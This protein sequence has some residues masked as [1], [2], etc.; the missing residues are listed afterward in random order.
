MWNRYQQL[1]R[2][3]P[4]F[5]CQI[6]SA[7]ASGL[8]RWVALEFSNYSMCEQPVLD[9]HTH[10]NT[11][12]D[13]HT[14]TR[15]LAKLLT[16]ISEC[17]NIK[18]Q[19][20]KIHDF[21]LLLLLYIFVCLPNY[22]EFW[23]QESVASEI[24]RRLDPRKEVMGIEISVIFAILNSLLN[25]WSLYLWLFSSHSLPLCHLCLSLTHTDFESILT[26]VFSK[27]CKSSLKPANFILKFS[28]FPLTL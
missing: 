20:F 14:H 3:F 28:C 22:I 24:S 1:S 19:P 18:A 10:I 8:L 15:T 26:L 11:H 13:T 16:L 5:Q 23:C 2:M 27:T 7:G 12:P 21:L 4:R 9:M 6:V 25:V 17:C